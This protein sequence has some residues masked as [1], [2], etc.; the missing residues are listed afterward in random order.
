MTDEIML[1]CHKRRTV[2][3]SWLENALALAFS[4]LSSPVAFDDVSFSV[5]AA[6]E[7]ELHLMIAD[8]QRKKGFLVQT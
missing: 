1:T 7:L 2:S 8:T 6:T 5:P 3:R 4:Q